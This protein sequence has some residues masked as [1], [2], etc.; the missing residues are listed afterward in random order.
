MDGDDDM[1]RDLG[2]EWYWPSNMKRNV[3]NYGDSASVV[4]KSPLLRRSTQQPTT[5]RKKAGQHLL[6]M[7]AIGTAVGVET[8]IDCF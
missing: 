4:L 6:W 1:N 2:L 3:W 5:V 7:S 8:G